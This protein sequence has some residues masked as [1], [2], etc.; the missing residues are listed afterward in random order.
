MKVVG[1]LLRATNFK[2]FGMIESPLLTPSRLE[3]R[4]YP[5]LPA[6]TSP[7][8]TPYALLSAMGSDEDGPYL[9][10]SLLDLEV[11]R[12]DA[13]FF[14]EY[15]DRPNIDNC[16]RYFA[17]GAM[18][19]ERLT[20]GSSQL[21]HAI[22][23]MYPS[24]GLLTSHKLENLRFIEIHHYALRHQRMQHFLD[25]QDTLVTVKL[26]RCSAIY[27]DAQDWKEAIWEIAQG[28]SSSPH[29]PA[30]QSFEIDFS[31]W[32]L[33]ALDIAPWLKGNTDIFPISLSWSKRIDQGIMGPRR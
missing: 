5:P 19:L 22:Q 28:Q 16:F 10:S 27:G 33:P 17:S 9:S 23:R 7:I 2:K 30:L 11:T 29:W 4:T 3:T 26:I 6:C 12:C 8:I 13:D 18:N 1:N 15:D 21:G 32:A 20:I 24:L 31:D 14:H 25:F